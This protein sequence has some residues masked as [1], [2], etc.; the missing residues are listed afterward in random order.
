MGIRTDLAVEAKA[1]WE[2]EAGE[3][4][5]LSGVV[6]RN[7]KRG[8]TE[9]THVEILNKE[10]QKALGKPVGNYITMELPKYDRDPSVPARILAQEL[11][12]LLDL[13]E[14]DS[15]LIVG[16]GNA[17]VTPD[18]L[19]PSAVGGLFLTR[20][21]IAGLPEQFGAC[22]CV[23]AVTPGVLATTGVESLE[24]VKG[25]VRHVRPD[26]ILVID[27]LAAAELQRLCTTVQLSDTGI[28]PGSGVGN[29]RAAFNKDSLGVPVCS[30]GVPTV[31]D[32]G[33]LPGAGERSMIVT[34]G[35]I[36]ERIRYLSRVLS[37]GINLAL[38]PEYDYEDFVQFVGN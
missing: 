9:I 16:L 29:C 2:R 30:L 5:K 18:A 38:H 31:V 24:L 14:K 11:S 35:D 27:A 19:G 33:G 13:K 7:R 22:R 12:E 15:V 17:A 10:G 3:T 32:G 26:R 21:L 25:V 23:S 28:H 1:L 34:P 6:A 20:H 8:D 37:A 4:T 36:D